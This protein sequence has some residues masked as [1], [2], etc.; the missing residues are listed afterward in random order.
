VQAE[1]EWI[2]LGARTDLDGR[3]IGV[4][5]TRL[6]DERGPI[7]RGVQTLIVRNRSL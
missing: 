2:G 5:D 7:G 4:A 3:G 6:Y 1:G